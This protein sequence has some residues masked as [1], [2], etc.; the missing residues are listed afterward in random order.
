M[1][2]QNIN[3]EALLA[4]P[5]KVTKTVQE[6]LQKKQWTV[7]EQLLKFA[8]QREPKQIF[9]I[10]QLGHLYLKQGKYEQAE[11]LLEQGHRIAPGDTVTIATLGKV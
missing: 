4:D 7:A 6:L 1:T 11:K 3:I 2:G 9:Y 10:N 5:R 8:H